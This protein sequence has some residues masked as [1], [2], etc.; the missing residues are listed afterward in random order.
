M[1]AATP[2]RNAN[3]ANVDTTKLHVDVDGLSVTNGN[4]AREDAPLLTTSSSS[5]TLYTVS[6]ASSP[7]SPSS[8]EE[9]AKKKVR[10]ASPRK[11]FEFP[12]GK[13]VVILVLNAVQPFAFELVF[14]FIST[15]IRGYHTL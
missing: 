1:S 12:W 9:G 8:P 4:K 13:V 3:G 5:S 15:F 7:E 11:Q 14:P 10:T 2:Y 6:R